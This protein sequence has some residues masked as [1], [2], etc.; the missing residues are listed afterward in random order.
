MGKKKSPSDAYAV[1]S[2]LPTAELCLNVLARSAVPFLYFNRS[3]YI[4]LWHNSIAFSMA[5]GFEHVTRA[6]KKSDEKIFA[7]GFSFRFSFFFFLL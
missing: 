4:T 2:S 3:L 6:E 1:R 5:V 7:V